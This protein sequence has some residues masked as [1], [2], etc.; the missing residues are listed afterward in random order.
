MESD[1]TKT[2]ENMDFTNRII[3][4]FTNRTIMDFTNKTIMDFTNKTTE[5]VHNFILKVNSL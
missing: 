1:T 4:D 3:M 5:I 2:S